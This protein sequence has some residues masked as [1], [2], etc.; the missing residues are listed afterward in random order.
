MVCRLR[1]ATGK[2]RKNAAEINPNPHH[3][4]DLNPNR[5]PIPH[6]FFCM[7]YTSSTQTFSLPTGLNSWTLGPFNVFILLNGWCVRLSML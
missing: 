5:N 3:N 4:P 6:L 2:L 1:N 7:L